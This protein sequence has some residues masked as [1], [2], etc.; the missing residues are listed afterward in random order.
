MTL[1]RT[2]EVLTLDV[3]IAIRAQLQE[4]GAYN[5]QGSTP[6]SVIRE[7]A[8][9]GP[10][11]HLPHRATLSSLGDVAALPI[12]RNKHRRWPK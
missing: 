12:H 1:D 10:T 7:A 2:Q 11:G 4:E 5:P 9:L 6:A 8:S 3:P